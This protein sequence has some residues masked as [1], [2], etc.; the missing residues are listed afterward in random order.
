MT[1]WVRFGFVAFFLLAAVACFVS[2]VIGIWRFGFVMNRIH[3][4]GVGDTLGL[5]CVTMSAVFRSCDLFDALKMILVLVFMWCTSPVAVHFL[6][7]V[8]YYTHPHLYR[9]VRRQ[10]AKEEEHGD[11]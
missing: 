4:G 2:E 7:K 10:P 11:H 5:F 1:E 9:H 3:A 6:S 8:E